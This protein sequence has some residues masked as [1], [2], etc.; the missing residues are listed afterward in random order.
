MG[1]DERTK[2]GSIAKGDADYP[3]ALARHL[4]NGAPAALAVIGNGDLLRRQTLALFCSV[5]CP[6]TAILRTY[7]LV[8]IFSRLTILNYTTMCYGAPAPR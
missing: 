5:K 2:T 7:D 8:R 6:G 1:N 4:N 3:P